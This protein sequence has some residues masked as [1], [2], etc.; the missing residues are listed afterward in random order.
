MS[1]AKIADDRIERTI[2]KRQVL[3]LCQ[4]EVDAWMSVS[5]KFD[6][7]WRQIDTDRPRTELECFGR[8][9]AWAG[10]HIEKVGIGS[11]PD[12]VEQRLDGGAP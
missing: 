9:R 4:A 2:R 5:R 11:K 1:Q 8:N 7:A 12:G 10:R 3:D 6:H